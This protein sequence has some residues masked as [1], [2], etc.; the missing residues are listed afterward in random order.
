MILNGVEFIIKGGELHVSFITK[1][2]FGN[3]AAVSLMTILVISHWGC[4][5]L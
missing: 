4:Q 2:A 1:W 3:K 5:L